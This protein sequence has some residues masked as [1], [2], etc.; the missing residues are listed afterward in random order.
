MLK[1]LPFYLLGIMQAEVNFFIY[2]FLFSSF[3]NSIPRRWISLFIIFYLVLSLIQYHDNSVFTSLPSSLLKEKHNG[4]IYIYIYIYIHILRKI[5][6][7]NLTICEINNKNK[8]NLSCCRKVYCY[9][10]HPLCFL[11]YID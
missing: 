1:I 4:N 5:T 8:N 3:I 2:H 9:T 10:H 11:L 7:P 6:F